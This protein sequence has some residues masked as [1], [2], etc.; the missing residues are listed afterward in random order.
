[1]TSPAGSHLRGALL[2]LAAFGVYATHDA[3]VKFL[4]GSYSP[5]QIIFFSTLLSF[6]LVTIMLMRD[7][8]DGNL[9]PRHPWWVAARTG[10]AIVTT[11]AAFYAFSVLTLA[12]AYAIFFSMPLMITLLAIPLLGE[13]VGPRR[14]MAVVAGL[15]GVLIVLRPG[16]APIG[17]GQV[18][19]LVAA[20]TG[21]FVS[22]VVRKIGQD[23]R[24]AVIM[25]YPM[26]ANFIFAAAIL[27]FVY[28]PMPFA[29]L[30]LLGLMSAL[31]FAG[32]LFIIAAYRRAP[33]VVVA[34]MQYSQILWAALYGTLFFRERLDLWTA[35]GTAIIIL[36]G[37]YIVLREDSPRVSKNRPVLATQGRAETGIF[38][39]LLGRI[40]PRDRSRG[41]G[42]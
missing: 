32:G 8:T 27:P 11:V 1:M 33:A 5:L 9:R 16:S 28:R 10:A 29:H 12:Q 36:S 24:S 21:A 30:A 13:R 3:A 15:A 39:R 7:P 14:G 40:A 26:V 20:T 25:L 42:S 18:A 6:P 2:S 37:V 23:E 35:V 31:G 34:P 4:G 41:E 17:L 19:A 22:V 38:P